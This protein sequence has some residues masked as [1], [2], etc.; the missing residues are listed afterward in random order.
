MHSAAVTDVIVVIKNDNYKI[1]NRTYFEFIYSKLSILILKL[2]D[3][4]NYVNGI[5]QI[6]GGLKTKT[7]Q[8]VCVRLMS[9]LMI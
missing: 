1:Q 2:R 6:F 5:L 8:I 9:L 4:M 7:T 3:C